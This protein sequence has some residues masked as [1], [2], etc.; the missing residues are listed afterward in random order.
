MILIQIQFIRFQIVIGGGDL[1]S[2]DVE[3]GNLRIA[4]SPPFGPMS[5]DW[6]TATGNNPVGTEWRKDIMLM[7]LS[8]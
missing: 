5:I 6:I 2:E 1:S 3:T 4:W 8:S 7:Q